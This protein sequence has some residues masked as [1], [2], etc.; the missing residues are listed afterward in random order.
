MTENL[1]KI[2]RFKILIIL[3]LA[4]SHSS[5]DCPSN[6][7][8]HGRFRYHIWIYTKNNIYIVYDDVSF[9]YFSRIIL[10]LSILYCEEFS[11]IFLTFHVFIILELMGER[12]VV[13]GCFHA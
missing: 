9:V 11:I 13:Y 2:N 10:S 3:R 4:G 7:S 5:K 1:L 12:N 6:I 8:P